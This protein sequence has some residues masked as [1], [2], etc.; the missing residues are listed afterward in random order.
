MK[1]VDNNSVINQLK[2]IMGIQEEE[3]EEEE[4]VNMKKFQDKFEQFEEI[5]KQINVIEKIE[6]CATEITIKIIQQNRPD[7][8]VELRD[9]SIYKNDF[10][11]QKEV[12][13][14]L[15]NLKQQKN[16]IKKQIINELEL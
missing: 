2:R 11:L 9:F 13:R 15:R 7:Y 10:Y 8:I 6:N 16:R 14:I 1:K 5:K 3:E 12:K 4:Q